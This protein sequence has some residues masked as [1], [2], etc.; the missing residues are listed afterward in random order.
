MWYDILVKNKYAEYF[1]NSNGTE[2]AE[3]TAKMLRGLAGVVSGATTS[4]A[5]CDRRDADFVA[6]ATEYM[7]A[8]E[9]LAFEFCHSNLGSTSTTSLS[10]VW[11]SIPTEDD[12]SKYDVDIELLSV[13]QC[14]V[15]IMYPFW[16][17]MGG[18][19]EE[20]FAADGRLRKYL[21]ALNVKNKL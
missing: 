19:F 6:V 21:R 18:S 5:F 3:A 17:R 11:Q 15:L 8:D 9:K 13:E 2:D 16:S 10:D 14:A 20:Q 12:Q 7:D 1:I 4:W